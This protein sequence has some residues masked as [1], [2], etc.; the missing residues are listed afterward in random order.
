MY[1][2]KEMADLAGVTTR[3]LRHYDQVSLLTPAEI[4]ENGYR[5]YDHENLL[6]LQQV[7]F[8]KEMDV[9]LKEIQFI[10]SRPDFQLLPA[11]E[12][13]RETIQVQIK[14]YQRLLKTIQRT[15]GTLQGENKMS[16]NEYFEGFDETQYEEE[17]RE[18]WG[19]TS[20]YAESQR[21]W[22]SYS[23]DQKEE[24]KQEGGRIT[25]RM[26]TEDPGAS[27]DDP[28]VQEA[29]GDY[30][31]YLNRYFYT[32]EV[33]FLRGLADMWVQDPRF[34]L[35]YERVREGGAVFVRDAVHIFCDRHQDKNS[36]N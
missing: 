21:K 25:I 32:C 26:V 29:V 2:I 24:I 20:Q 28:E 6:R 22:S 31:S 30:Y 10:L 4:G 17:T 8:F 15:I 13:H 33:G 35:N 18:R 16:A 11:L 1:T 7:L 27:P 14:R 36:E 12:N 19:N 3:T 34:A 5:Y 23:K 9:P